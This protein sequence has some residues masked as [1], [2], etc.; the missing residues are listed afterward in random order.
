LESERIKEKIE[1]KEYWKEER[2]G[3]CKKA[4]KEGRL[5]SPPMKVLQKDKRIEGKVLYSK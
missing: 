4:C 2:K 3:S 1:K 5:L